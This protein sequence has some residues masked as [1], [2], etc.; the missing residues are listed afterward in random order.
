MRILSLSRELNPRALKLHMAAL[1]SGVALAGI[2]TCPVLADDFTLGNYAPGHYPVGNYGPPYATG[3]GPND[4]H[5][6]QTIVDN[7]AANTLGGSYG[8]VQ[9]G[10]SNTSQQTLQQIADDGRV[11]NGAVLPEGVLTTG[12]QNQQVTY[13]DPVTQENVTV[14]VYNSN[15]FNV[16]PDAR[17]FTI[18]DDVNDQEAY[19]DPR[20]A[21]VSNGSSL[22]VVVGTPGGDTSAAGNTL[23]MPMKA[24]PNTNGAIISAYE[25]ND[26]SSLSYDTSTR[27]NLGNYPTPGSEATTANVSG[28]N[29]D[30]GVAIPAGAT[31]VNPATGLT[32][33][34]PAGSVTDVTSFQNYNNYLIGQI[35]QGALTVSDY[36]ATLAAAYSTNNVTVEYR[37][38]EIPKYVQD[39]PLGERTLIHGTGTAG[40]T[41]K[42]GEKL[43]DVTAGG[44]HS[45]AYLEDDATL[46]NNGQLS[47]YYSSHAIV[48]HDN[49]SVHNSGTGVISNFIPDAN[50][51]VDQS[52]LGPYSRGVVLDDTAKFTNDGIVNV[53]AST[54]LPYWLTSP[55]NSPDS[56]RQDDDAGR[57]NAGIVLGGNASAVNTAA[58][59]INVGVNDAGGN[60]SLVDGVYLQGDATFTNEGDINIGKSAQFEAGAAQTDTSNNSAILTGIRVLGDGKATNDGNIVIGANTGRA[61]AMYAGSGTHGEAVGTGGLELINNGSIVIDG[62]RSGTPNAN[63]AMAA[64]NV[65]GKIEHNG[66]IELN[67]VNARGVYVLGTTVAT[68]AD[69]TTDSTILVGGGFNPGTNTRNYGVWV[70]G[71]KATADVDGTVNLEGVGGIGVHARQGAVI[72]LGDT[73]EINFVSGSDQIGYFIHGAGS[74]INN[75]ANDLDVSTDRSTLFRIEDG[76]SYDGLGGGDARTL[77]A[78]GA[79]A[80]ILHVT[81]TNTT[82]NTGTGTY[83]LTGEGAIAVKSEG[84][85]NVTIDADTEI[86]LD[87][88]DTIAG[89]V[90]GRKLDL[91]GNVTGTGLASRLTNNAEITSNSDGVTGFIARNGGALDNNA[92]ITFT[93]EDAIGVIVETGGTADNS[94]PIDITDGTGI[95]VRK[96]GS[97]TNSATIDIG[98]GEGVIVQDSGIFDNEAGGDITVADGTGLLVENTDGTTS[99]SKVSNAADILVHDGVAGIHVRNG[100][101]LDASD[102]KGTVTVDGTA[103]GVLIGTGASGLLLGSTEITV[104]GTGNGIENAAELGNVELQDTVINLEGAGAGIRTGTS[105]TS[106]SSAE[107]NVKGNGG[108]G[109]LFELA[110]GQSTNKNLV[111]SDLYEI[112]LE[113]T[114]T[115]NVGV[116]VNTTGNAAIATPIDDLGTGNVAIRITNADAVDIASDIAVNTTSGSGGTGIYVTNADSVIVRGDVDVGAAGGSALVIEHVATDATNLGALTSLSSAPVVDLSPSTGTVFDNFGTIE[117]KAYDAV[118]I[119][120]SAGA[121]DVLLGRAT[122]GSTTYTSA[123][124]GI[125]RMGDGTDTVEWSQGTLVGSIEMGAGDNEKLEVIGRDLSTVYHLDGGAGIGDALTF[126]N[127]E[128]YGGSFATDDAFQNRIKGINLGQGWETIDFLNG[129]DFTLTG[130]LLYGDQLT[131]DE[132]SILRAGNNV[133]ATLGLPGADFENRGILDF[134]NGTYSLTDTATVAGN[135][136]GGP[137]SVVVLNTYLASDNSP[138]DKLIVNGGTEGQ[139]ALAIIRDSASPGAAT[140]GDGILVVRVDEDANSNAVF[141]APTMFAGAYEYNLFQG[142]IANP[143][144]GDWYL[145]SERSTATQTLGTYVDSLL[146]FAGMIGT[147]QQRVGNR[148]W[149][150]PA[151]TSTIWCKDPA[152]N[153]NC[154]VTKAQDSVYAD[155]VTGAPVR[156]GLWSRVVAEKGDLSPAV[157]TPYERDAW[158]AQVGVNG[159]LTENDRGTLLAGVFGTY[160]TQSVDAHVTALPTNRAVS[161]TGSIDTDAYGVGGNLTWLG[162]DGTYVDGVGQFFWYQSDLSSTGFGQFADGNDARSYTLSL[163]VGRRFEIASGFGIVPQAQLIYSNAWTDDFTFSNPDP[164][165]LANTLVSVTDGDADSLR[166][167]LGLRFE[168]LGNWGAQAHRGQFQAYAITNL[169]YEFLDGSSIDVA[170][171]GITQRNDRL[172]GEVGLGGTVALSD[173]LS[174]YGEA[175]YQTSLENFGDSDVYGGNVGLRLSW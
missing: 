24:S 54:S 79:G 56:P 122:D 132:T 22:S 87:A 147:M 4:D 10:V 57:W 78:S 8:T 31:W 45:I 70:Q 43:E 28:V 86:N 7:G 108:T 88:D 41:V 29:F 73:A 157:G 62:N 21:T 115:N 163:E 134:T 14:N 27:F 53:A 12:Q 137:D 125:V 37:Q 145:R 106:A 162:H 11:L 3:P 5:A 164:D 32:E 126:S 66:S 13:F 84:G 99:T 121:D 18:W 35:Q 65:Q 130:D 40:I 83:T 167:R 143:L 170:G 26:T 1:L 20:L 119:L 140:K 175:R 142:G 114:S 112:N 81:G 171:E 19:L 159:V 110:N 46:D 148:T 51:K 105:F 17:T 23:D 85:A 98:S 135:Y 91:A 15:N 49:A 151:P 138:T 149:A 102:F 16:T 133:N 67:G 127:V 124:T 123:V 129:T 30:Q 169:Y 152:Q 160:G 97:A 111:L 60:V 80:T 117:T 101:A 103:H 144:D 116:D 146:G 76:A 47:S 58:G 131:L 161:R 96:S 136:V 109:F 72:D 75:I 90:D 153:F 52:F 95:L 93:G 168:N 50:G 77:T 61:V 69:V 74:K 139:T 173:T 42:E 104:K 68:H 113:A 36:Q 33:A 89:I 6:G 156:S 118:A 165:P 59:A 155:S 55:T 166:A 44:S 2:S 100:A 128:Y 25:V 150:E 64:E 9:G 158:F 39:M 154:K 38:A 71:S 34:I 120:G 174:L 48:G 94:G 172:W 63:Y 107:I 92:A 82:A 141:T